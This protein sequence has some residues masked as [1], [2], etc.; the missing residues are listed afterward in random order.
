MR[1]WQSKFTLSAV[2]ALVKRPGARLRRLPPS[3]SPGPRRAPADYAIK[4]FTPHSGVYKIYRDHP[5]E[6]NKD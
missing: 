6:V 3:D 5:Q 4:Q 2:L 1:R